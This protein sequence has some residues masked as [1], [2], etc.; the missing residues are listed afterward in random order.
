MSWFE[1]GMFLERYLVY[2]WDCGLFGKVPLGTEWD[3]GWIGKVPEVWCGLERYLICRKS[4]SNQLRTG[5][6]E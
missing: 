4:C 5:S 1:Q 6:R 3:S 2:R